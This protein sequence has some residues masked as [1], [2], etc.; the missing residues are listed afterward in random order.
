[1][2][3]KNLRCFPNPFQRLDHHGVPTSAYPFDP[4]HSPDRRWVG[5]TVDRGAGADGLPRTRP[6]ETEGDLTAVLPRGALKGKLLHVDRAPRKRV[7][8]AF[9]LAATVI[10]PTSHYLLGFRQG[11]LIP[12]DEETARAVSRPFVAPAVVLLAAAGTAIAA[13]EREHGE[14]PD[15]E[16]WPENLRAVAG[17]LPES[18]KKSAAVVVPPSAA[19][20]RDEPEIEATDDG[21]G[22]A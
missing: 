18:E 11:S 4:S 13:W 1:M 12:A 10:P 3:M 8:F 15:F 21:G 16:L 22:E 17:R 20:Q 9:D 2:K 19:P 7:Q 6:L 14:L 5:A